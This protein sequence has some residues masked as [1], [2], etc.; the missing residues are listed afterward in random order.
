MDISRLAESAERKARP[1][2]E[3]IDAI[4]AENTARVLAAFAHA[5]V[6]DGFFA[7]TTGYG[8]DDAGRAALEKIYAEVLG[9]EKALVRLNFVN[10]SH[11]IACAMTSCLRSGDT[12][13][14]VTGAPYDTLQTLIGLHGEVGGTFS[15][16]GIKYAQV[17]LK[18]GEPDLE[19]I[20]LAAKSASAV[21][22]QRSRGYAVRKTLSCADVK[23]IADAVR[24]VNA[25]APIIVDN[26]YG[27]FCETAEPLSFGADLICG[28]LIKNPG[29]GLAPGG[30]YIAGRAD[31]CDRAAN[32]LTL[33][34]I[35]GECG[36]TFGQN[37]LLFQGFLMAPH[38]VAQAL[39]TA[40]FAAAA[41]E[42]LGYEVSPTYGEP[43]Y[44]IIQTVSFKKPEPLLAFCRGIQEGAPVDSYVTPEPWEM[45]GYDCPV[46]MAAGAF[47][48]GSSIELSCDA[49]MRE[50]FTAYLQG[51]LTYEAGKLGVLKGLLRLS[52][53]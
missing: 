40:V 49:P 50:P 2:F 19:G 48:Q 53:L 29:G 34:G 9:A 18:N 22:I 44:D 15:E 33:P 13:L 39:K 1:Q 8:Y 7:G 16:Y 21:F 14:S 23:E 35:G 25:S 42:E 31:L 30:G 24:S 43:R 11:A 3:R 52:E 46:V 51:G 20:R 45:P 27:E 28:S 26:C 6:S 32:R 4:A 10:G 36:A 12:L 41:L 38:T 37:R 17:D 47:I 5:R